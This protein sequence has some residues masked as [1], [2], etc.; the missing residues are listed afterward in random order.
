M[1]VGDL[2]TV[3][4]QVGVLVSMQPYQ[5]WD[6]CALL[7]VREATCQ[8]HT[9][10]EFLP[11]CGRC[12]DGSGIVWDDESE[13]W[14]CFKCLTPRLESFDGPTVSI[15]VR[16]L[17]ETGTAGSHTT[18][19]N[20]PCCGNALTDVVL[21]TPWHLIPI[22]CRLCQASM[23]V[24]GL[25][26]LPSDKKVLQ[27]LDILADPAAK[28]YVPQNFMLSQHLIESSHRKSVMSR[29]NLNMMRFWGRNAYAVPAF[30]WVSGGSTPLDTTEAA[31]AVRDVMMARSVSVDTSKIRALGWRRNPSRGIFVFKARTGIR[32]RGWPR[33]MMTPEPWGRPRNRPLRNQP[34]SNRSRVGVL[35]MK[36]LVVC[37]DGHPK[38][39]R[40]TPAASGFDLRLR[41]PGLVT[42]QPGARAVLPAGI[43]LEIPDGY[44]GQV[45]PRSGRSRDG[46]DVAFGTIDSDYRGEVGVTVINNTG[47]PLTIAPQ[48]RI[49]Q[50]VF[51]AVP[52]V[53]LEDADQL[54]EDTLRG[55][56]GYGSTGNL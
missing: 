49:A 1:K 15:P 34:D 40:S 52:E 20:C 27:T 45:R 21:S 48:E 6:G 28:L 35:M 8:V 11:K 51:T 25:R 10:A 44:E 37:I 50:I 9:D 47:R 3:G 14:L 24:G 4:A 56:G 31:I 29:P 7:T 46:I 32:L 53:E 5:V 12:Q 55:S 38:P 26:S 42:I 22:E 54:F 30:V 13:Q 43:R 33:I 17:I 16:K 41:A 39:A 18:F 19:L 36:V 23:I 2:V